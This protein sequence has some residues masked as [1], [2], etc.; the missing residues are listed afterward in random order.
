MA[1]IKKVITD[2]GLN[3]DLANISDDGTVNYLGAVNLS[4]KGLKKIPI[5]FGYVLG[6][7]NCSNNFLTSLKNAPKV[8][9]GDF[10]CSN[11]KLKTLKYSPL[12][13]KG[14]FYCSRNKLVS[15]EGCPKDI[16]DSFECSINQL[17]SLEHCPENV[18]GYFSAHQNNIDTLKYFP[19]K[20]L[21]YTNLCKNVVQDISTLGRFTVGEELY[22]GGNPVKKI[23]ITNAKEIRYTPEELEKK[24]KND[25]VI[26]LKDALDTSL[27]SNSEDNK[28][29]LKV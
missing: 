14:G 12:T 9:Q 7:F 4:K 29:K 11:N 25:E 13:V 5:K 2:L 1:W 23:V 28:R 8:V 26:A 21:G 17:N 3:V 18:L 15:L 27:N 16:N 24:F 20:I 19:K 22:I 10:Y 6:F